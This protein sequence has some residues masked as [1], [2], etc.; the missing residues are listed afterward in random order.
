V[1]PDKVKRFEGSNF[2]GGEKVMAIFSGDSLWY[3]V[4]VKGSDTKGYDVTF[5]KFGNSET[6]AKTHVKQKVE[7]KE[8]KKRKLQIKEVPE[9]LKFDSTD[10]EAVKATKRKKV[11]Q[12]KSHNRSVEKD[13]LQNRRQNNW[14]S[15]QNK[16]M[17]RKVIGKFVGRKK[18]SMFATP[19]GD[20]GKVGVVG[21]GQEMTSFVNFEE[22]SRHR[23]GQGNDDDDIDVD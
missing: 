13:L 17:K 18:E 23:Q 3:D 8:D 21:S 22:R 7:S 6:V 4:V 10:T 2:A 9:S 19:E 11:K 1:I 16:G 12:I 14:T 20:I 15:F 5:S